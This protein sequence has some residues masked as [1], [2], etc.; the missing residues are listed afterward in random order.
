MMADEARKEYQVRLGIAFVAYAILLAVS[1]P[2]TESNP[3]AAWRSPLALI[4]MVPFLYGIQ[5][6]VRYLRGVDELQ[7][8]IALE[9]LAIAF[10]GTA[11]VTFGYGFLQNVGLPEVNWMFVWPVMAGLWILGGVYAHRRYG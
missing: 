3:T 5:V 2:L 9:S 7:R 8:R 6:Y 10:G 1:L 11:A 4:P